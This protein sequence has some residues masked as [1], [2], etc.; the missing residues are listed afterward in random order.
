[1]CC[2]CEAQRVDAIQP[3]HVTADALRSVEKGLTFLSRSQ[4]ANGSWESL[5]DGS[6][7]PCAMA[8]LAG[9]AFLAGGNTP[10]RGPHAAEVNR[11]LSFVLAHS[12]PNGLIAD[13]RESSMSMY[14]H[15]FSLLFLAC[16]YGM[17]KDAQ[18]RAEIS[19]VIK[20]A[21]K[22]TSDAQSDLGGWIYTPRRW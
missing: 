6:T 17:E 3:K 16:V 1:M 4:S 21:I 9:M 20:A 10:T 5:P 18:R 7:Y 12:G 13:P 15:G 11:T 22:L 19:R 2:R 8:S 14:G